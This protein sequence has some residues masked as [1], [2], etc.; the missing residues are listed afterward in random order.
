[1]PSPSATRPATIAPRDLFLRSLSGGA[2]RSTHE[3][4]AAAATAGLLPFAPVNANGFKVPSDYAPA[5]AAIVAGAAARTVESVP[6]HTS[7]GGRAPRLPTAPPGNA[8]ASA[9]AGAPGGA[10]AGAWCAILLCSL[11]FLAQHLRRHRVRLSTPA[12]SGVVLLLH[13]PG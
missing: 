12:P 11:L 10:T 13:R 1:V 9:I 2:A 4:L 5:M 3:L 8:G 6:A 7:R